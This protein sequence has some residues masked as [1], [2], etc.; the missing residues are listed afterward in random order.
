LIGHPR[1]ADQNPSAARLALLDDGLFLSPAALESWQLAVGETILVQVGGRTQ[2]LRI[3]GQL[4]AA[5]AGQRL[6]SM[7]IGF[8]QWRF[9]RL[10]KLT[11]IDLQL[12]PGARLEQLAA[13]VALPAG[14]YFE[15]ANQT[16]TRVS[17]LSRAYR[18]NLSALAL[19]ALFTGSFLVYS[20]QSQGVVARAR[21]LAFLRVIGVTE[22]ETEQLLVAEAICFGVVGAALG[23]AAGIA[24]AASALRWLGGDLGGGYF[25][26]VRPALVVD[27]LQA[28]GFFVL[29]VAAAAVGGWF[30][31]RAIARAEPAPMLKAT[32]GIE[33]S[34][35][36]RPWFAL[37][38][39]VLA[40]A[41]LLLPPARGVPVAA[42]G[43]IGAL[44]VAAIAL[45]PHVAPHLFVPLAR[46]AG[47]RRRPHAAVWLALQRLGAMPRFAAVGAAGIVASFALMV[48]MATMVNSFR[49]SVDAWLARVLPADVYARAAPATAASASSTAYF[50]EADQQRMRADPQVMRADFSRSVKLVLD[51]A[52]APITLLARPVDRNRPERTLPLTGASRP[53]TPTLPPPAWVSEA[54]VD[55]YGAQVGREFSVPLAGEEHRFF[56]AGVWRDYARQ[57]GSVIVDIADYERLSGDRL[58]TDAALWLAP[59]ASAAHLIESLRNT[60]QATTAEFAQTG[61]VR[62][63]SLRIFD[64]SFAV[65]YILEI[66]A[67][68]I[69]LTGI[70]ATFSAQAIARRRE[71]GMLRHIGMT[72]G[73]IG[74][75]LAAEGGLLALLGVAVGLALG[76]A[77]SLVLIHVV[78][79]QSFNWSMDVHLPYGLLVVLSLV[80]IF[81][82]ALTAWL[83]GRE[84]TGIGPVRAVK[85]DW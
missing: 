78:N 59:G 50:S 4:P 39:V 71:F 26:G 11:R 6:A 29:G 67:I 69:G 1:D 34:Q 5:R 70:A 7:D 57:G 55:L 61:E 33:R 45:K 18:I 38:L 37:G 76:G 31:A 17:N 72:R 9:D 66:A 43:A 79:R 51:P 42:Y 62:A 32:A 48:A 27:P 28:I 23:I 22:H 73:G 41:L 19:V 24:L 82:S 21:Q 65:T 3:V 80:L 10:G 12:A 30:P 81:L 36:S 74:A 46:W 35:G 84:A 16:E 54:M 13:R 47:R 77:I 64:R 49:T 68:V 60:L 63:V 75:M 25:T 20:L 2:N 14:I 40:C 58:R 56:V 8:A 15:S 52:R 83:S 44:L 85:E 53:W